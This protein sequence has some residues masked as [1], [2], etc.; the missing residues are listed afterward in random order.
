MAHPATK[1]PRTVC[2]QIGLRLRARR[3]DL[4]MPQAELARLA[5]VSVGTIKNLETRPWATSL[6]SLVCATVPLRLSH[7]L[8]PLFKGGPRFLVDV[9]PP[10]G[11]P[12]QR[13]RQRA[14]PRRHVIAS[15]AGAAT[16]ASLVAG[17]GL[18]PS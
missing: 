14:R 17:Y 18:K 4:R 2:L 11:A 13:A 10:G 16:R 9:R 8:A 5:G 12:R 7:Q 3:L 1:S 15:R 6:E